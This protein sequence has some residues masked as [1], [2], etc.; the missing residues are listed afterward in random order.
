MKKGRVTHSLLFLARTLS[1]QADTRISAVAPQKMAKKAVLR[2]QI[3]R[4]T[5][6]AVHPIIN[7]V[8]QGLW[9]AIFAKKDISDIELNEMT[10]DLRSLFGSKRV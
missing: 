7:L 6:E 8:P 2:N 3:R 9:V 1:G 10:T 5:Y 4:R